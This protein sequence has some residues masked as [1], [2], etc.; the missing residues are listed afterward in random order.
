MIRWQHFDPQLENQ[1]FARY[2]IGSEILITILVFI[3]DY[4]QEKLVTKF[5]K[6]SKK[7]YFE[8]ILVPFCTNLGKSRT[9]SLNKTIQILN[10]LNSHQHAQNQILSSFYPRDMVHLKMLWSNWSRAFAPYLRDQNFIKYEIC[11]SI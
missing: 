7:R 8:A 3:L 4:F 10:L 9:I 1:N 2:G 5:K 6:K 11:L